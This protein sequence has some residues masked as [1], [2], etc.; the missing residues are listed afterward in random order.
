MENLPDSKITDEGLVS[1]AF[2]TLGIYSFKSACEYVRDL[3]YGRIFDKFNLISVLEEGRGTC[4]SKHALLKALATENGLDVQ[5]FIGIFQ[6]H[7]GN[8]PGVGRVLEKEGLAYVPEA[9]CYLKY[10][11]KITD[12]TGLSDGAEELEI[13]EEIEIEPFQVTDFKESYH[14]AYVRNWCSDKDFESIWKVREL[15]IQALSE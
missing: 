2:L 6:M 7:E 10:Q 9:H 1:K 8:T 15:C 4:S 14:K 3:H 12:I 11:D 13:L 5:L